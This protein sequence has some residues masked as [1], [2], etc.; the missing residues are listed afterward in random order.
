ASPTKAV[1]KRCPRFSACR[2]RDRSWLPFS[3]GTCR[4]L[5]CKKARASCADTREFGSGARRGPAT[6]SAITPPEQPPQRLK[7]QP[8]R[9]REQRCKREP[10]AR[11]GER[12]YPVAERRTG[13][14]AID[15][16]AQVS[17]LMKQAAM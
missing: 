10:I 1:W 8:D 7:Q 6:R 3:R 16:Q 2:I 12:R 17:H 11:E 14:A 13:K 9:N 15:V 5:R 4:F